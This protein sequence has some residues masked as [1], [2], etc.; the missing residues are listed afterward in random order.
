MTAGTCTGANIG[1]PV[2]RPVVLCIAGKQEQS[3]SRAAGCSL[4]ALHLHL[5]KAVNPVKPA[6]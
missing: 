5:P 6:E 1:R 4:Q 2:R 3:S